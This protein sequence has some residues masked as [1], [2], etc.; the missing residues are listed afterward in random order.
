MDGDDC[1][2]VLYVWIVALF[3][4]DPQE[5]TERDGTRLRLAATEGVVVY[6]NNLYVYLFFFFFILLSVTLFHLNIF[7][8]F[9][10]WFVTYIF[11]CLNCLFFSK[12]IF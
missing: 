1:C 8:F 11:L 4:S 3:N 6:R 5:D 9:L 2:Q 10:N 12:N 7:Y